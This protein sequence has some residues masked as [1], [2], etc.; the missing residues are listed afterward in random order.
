MD[1]FKT[2]GIDAR[3]YGPIGKGLGR[4]TQE[5]VDNIVKLDQTNHY[6]IFLNRH[7][8]DEF[9]TTDWRVR[10]VLANARWYSLAEQITF[11][12]R[13]WRAKLDLMHFPHF[14]VPLV[15]PVKF[16]VTIHDLILTKFPTVKATTRWPIIYW[17]K[18]LGYRLVVWSAI[19]RAKKIITVSKFTKADLVKEFH[20][21]AKKVYVTYEGV[22]NLAK[23]NDTLFSSKLDA[24]KTLQDYHLV[25]PFLLY[26]GNAYPHKNLQRLLK[27]FQAIQKTQPNLRLVMVGKE[28]YFYNQLK[29]YAVSLGL[30][31]NDEELTDSHP[32]VFPGYVPDIK[33]EVL[34][35]QALA[36]VFPSLYEGF[37][38]PPLEAMAKDCAVVSSDRA[39]LP[40]ILGK[41]ALYFDPENDVDMIAKISQIIVDEN[42]R[43]RLKKLGQQQIKRYNWWECTRATYNLYQLALK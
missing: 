42:L 39:S 9:T 3:F 17:F 24:K 8:F 15:C 20:A 27:N 38:L 12:I 10:K 25:A 33:L 26:V 19:K 14:N 40:E 34:Y 30:W 43:A 29:N 36:Y 23:G 16:V 35:R 11:P 22:A 4:Y 18:N 41:A 28:D 13:I 7:N 6:V 1:N 37:G 5:I 32:L 21:Q 31:S 2:I